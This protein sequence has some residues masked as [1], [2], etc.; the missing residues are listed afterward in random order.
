MKNYLSLFVLAIVVACQPQQQQKAEIKPLDVTYPDGIF[1][2]EYDTFDNYAWKPFIEIQIRGGKIVSAT[3]DEINQSGEYKSQNQWYSETM[4]KQSG[5]TPVEASNELI[6][7]LVARNAA[8]IDTVTGATHTSER[9]RVLADAVLKSVLAGRTEKTVLPLD[10]VYTVETDRDGENYVTKLQ[11]TFKGG[12]IV[13]ARLDKIDA[14]NNSFRA[15]TA[16]ANK[17]WDKVA[18]DLEKQLV[19]KQQVEMLTPPAGGET[20]T[21]VMRGLVRRILQKRDYR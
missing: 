4:K 17:A 3:W 6:D 1:R 9:F 12:K 10:E 14:N 19:E 21:E 7:R 8:D 11:L 20:L 13:E 5:V 2:G 18:K 16:E 15:G